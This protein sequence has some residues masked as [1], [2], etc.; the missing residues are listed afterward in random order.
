[1]I[2]NS[3]GFVIVKNL[4]SKEEALSLAKH[5]K[6]HEEEGDM[7]D[8]FVPNS[9]SF[10][11]DKTL[12][13]KHIELLHEIEKH[14]GYRLFKT[15]NYARIYKK[16]AVLRIHRDRDECEISLTLDLGGDPWS[17]WITDKDENPIEVKLNIG[18]ALI[19][20]GCE[21]WHWRSKFNGDEHSQVFMHFVDANGPYSHLRNDPN[22]AEHRF[23]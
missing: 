8:P 21:I 9:P 1:M 2:F 10:Y 6:E 3:E 4:I 15:Y 22:H 23:I 12:N 18:D 16:G 7:N 19:Y 5:L 11:N 14:T 20:K 13:E 17:I